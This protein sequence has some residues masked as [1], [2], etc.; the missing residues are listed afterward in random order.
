MEMHT[1]VKHLRLSYE[2]L[3]AAYDGLLCSFIDTIS[4][5]RAEREELK[6]ENQDLTTRIERY[7][8]LAQDQDSVEAMAPK[9][10]RKA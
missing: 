9:Q 6:A 2:E 7:R 10:R 4:E 5:L 3:A 8:F 1:S